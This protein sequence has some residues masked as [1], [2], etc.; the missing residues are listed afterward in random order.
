MLGTGSEALAVGN[1]DYHIWRGP[2]RKSA[3][4]ALLLHRNEAATAMETA[5]EKFH[6][7]EVHRITGD[8]WGRLN[9]IIPTVP[10]AMA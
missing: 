10:G 1:M 8:T 2:R 7:A 3:K 4:L 5:K 6:E 9:N